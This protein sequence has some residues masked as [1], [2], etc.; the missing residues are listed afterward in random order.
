MRIPGQP[1]SLF[2]VTDQLDLWRRRAIRNQTVLCAVEDEHLAVDRQ[3]GNDIR[4]LRLVASLVD[5]ARMVDLLCDLELDSRSCLATMP[6]NLSTFLVI[7]VG[8]GRYSFG[9][10]DLGNL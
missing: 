6:A 7:V 5:L 8:I 10:L 1:E 3:R 4:V 9:Y 2:A